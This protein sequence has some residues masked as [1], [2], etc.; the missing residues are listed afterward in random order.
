M[1]RVPPRYFTKEITDLSVLRHGDH[2][3]VYK[4]DKKIAEGDLQGRPWSSALAQR[5]GGG[6]LR[7]TTPGGRE[8]DPVNDTITLAAVRPGETRQYSPSDTRDFRVGGLIK[9]FRVT[10]A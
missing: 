1:K 10:P 4:G 5:G 8:P 7:S 6:Q 3:V 2:V 9:I